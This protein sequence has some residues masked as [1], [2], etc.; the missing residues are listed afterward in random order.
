ME[1]ALLD[2]LSEL[3]HRIGKIVKQLKHLRPVDYEA[4]C[5]RYA[6]HVAVYQQVPIDALLRSRGYSAPPRMET[7]EPTESHSS[8]SSSSFKSHHSVKADENMYVM[9]PT[10]ERSARSARSTMT[11]NSEVTDV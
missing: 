2:E 8:S 9:M 4:D 11:L 1:H 5:N 7:L 10:T 6:T 3:H